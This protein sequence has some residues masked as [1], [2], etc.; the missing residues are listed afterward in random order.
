[1]RYVDCSS[2]YGRGGA[3]KPVQSGLEKKG[4]RGIVGAP[5]DHMTWDDH[6]DGMEADQEFGAARSN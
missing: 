3:E 2:D 4:V 6:H 1:M 5:R